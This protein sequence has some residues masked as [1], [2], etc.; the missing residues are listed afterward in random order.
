[1]MLYAP[2]Y[3]MSANRLTAPRQTMNRIAALR[4]S[5]LDAVPDAMIYLNRSRASRAR[6]HSEKQQQS[7]A[8]VANDFR[9]ERFLDP[10]ACARAD[11]CGE[12]AFRD[13]REHGAEP[14][15]VNPRWL[16]GR[17][18]HRLGGHRRRRDLP[19]VAPLGKENRG[20]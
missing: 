2:S 16:R 15:H 1:M 10:C 3:V 18:G 7:D 14:D 4:S 6:S 19:D 12:R 5:V 20:E 17:F 8:A 13:H 11:R 9:R